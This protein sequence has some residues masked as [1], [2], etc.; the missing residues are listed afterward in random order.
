MAIELKS[1]DADELKS[2]YRIIQRYR[3]DVLHLV[4]LYGYS[5]NDLAT[6]QFEHDVEREFGRQGMQKKDED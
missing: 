1:L 4:Q 2:L 5:M 6:K 3:E